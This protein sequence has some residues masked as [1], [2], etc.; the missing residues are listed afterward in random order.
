MPDVTAVAW[1][2]VPPDTA[3]AVSQTTGLERG[4][5]PRLQG[6]VEVLAAAQE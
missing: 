6:R 4:L 5:R 1:V 3:F 2:P